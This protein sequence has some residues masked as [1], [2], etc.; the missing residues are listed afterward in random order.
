MVDSVE[1]ALT[2]AFGGYTDKVN[3]QATVVEANDPADST[4]LVTIHADGDSAEDERPRKDM[5]AV[6][7]NSDSDLT[8]DFLYLGI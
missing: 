5:V 3:D 1:M 2:I 7:C 6:F 8:S 4:P